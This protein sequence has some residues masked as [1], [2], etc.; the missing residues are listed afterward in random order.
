MQITRR[1]LSRSLAIYLFISLLLAYSSLHA[2]QNVDW[3]MYGEGTKEQRFS[4]LEK[5]NTKNVSELGLEWF[6]DTDYNR[7]QQATPI[8]LDGIMYFTTNWSVVYAVDARSGELIWRYDPQVPKEWGKMACCDAVNRG[9]AVAD[10]KVVVGTLDT[11][12]LALDQ[13]TGELIWS[14][15][16]ADI[17]KWP[18]TVT[19][20]PRIAKGLVFIGNGGAEFGV[21]GY[22]SAY[23]LQS[24]GLVWRFYTVP[25][26]PDEGF[27]QPAMAKAAETWTGEWWN[28]GGGGTVWDSIVYDDELDQLY[29][30]VGNGSPWNQRIRSPE[31]G[32]NLYLSSIVALNPDTGAYIWHYQSTPA[33]SW[34][35]TATQHIMLAD[36][37][38]EGRQRKVIWQAPKN[39]FFFLVDRTNGEFISAEQFARVNWAEG[40]DPE[41]GRPIVTEVAD[42]SK[43]PKM[44]YPAPIGAHSWHPMAH[45]P[46]TGLV[47]F[48]VMDYGHQYIN[49]EDNEWRWGE[50]NLGV[51]MDVWLPESPT[52]VKLLV[53]RLPKGHLI[54]WD[55]ARQEAAWKVDR[56][57]AVNGGVL[58][59]AGDL[60]FQGTGDGLLTAVDAATGDSL[61]EFDAQA[62]IIAPPVTF[63]V[64][65]EQY[66]SV[67]VGMGG[68]VS[69]IGGFEA[70]N[71]VPNGRL[72][73]FKLGSDIALPALP[74]PP[75]Q[76]S[77]PERPNADKQTIELGNHIY[78]NYCHFCHGTALMANNAVPDLRNLPMLF[79]N[80]WDAIVRDGM[81]AKA[82]MVGFGE[83]LSQEETDAI[84]AYVIDGAYRQRE[85]ESGGLWN[86]IKNVFY[87]TAAEAIVF[88]DGLVN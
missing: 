64:D 50:W 69:L 79:Y 37:E 82:G 83:V 68:A 33:E 21:R 45:H 57:L 73:T 65:G 20:A 71:P 60:V 32:D 85:E 28:Y 87:R 30:G 70:Q 5:I 1:L 35:Y 59:T 38:W 3:P 47:Y 29:I 52:L 77:L 46:G 88:W 7:G 4:Q 61:W 10:G 17:E 75:K 56:K 12:L 8:V 14:T 72:L 53:E 51:D 13:K 40:Y 41:T 80:N 76:N 48:P 42:Y 16:T 15:Q 31:G 66:V 9:V 25:G 36:M 24:G 2:E 55:P 44:I 78:H 19:G 74:E 39:G 27:E 63:M 34:D 23:D 11:R 67:L 81:M 6:F 86:G 62:G 43:K 54:A 18:Y 58:A 22:V 26:N 49:A 84:Y